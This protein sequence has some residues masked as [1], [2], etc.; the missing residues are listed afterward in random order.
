MCPEIGQVAEATLR[1]AA[2]DG[3]IHAPQ[4]GFSSDS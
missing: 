3:D 2:E 1:W 4:T